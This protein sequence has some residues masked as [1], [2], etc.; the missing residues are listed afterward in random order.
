MI[1]L[2]HTCPV[3]YGTELFG[4]LRTKDLV[5]VTAV[6][7]KML[8]RTLSEFKCSLKSAKRKSRNGVI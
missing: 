2:A 8:S 3:N 7:F 4:S 1:K 6:V 5:R